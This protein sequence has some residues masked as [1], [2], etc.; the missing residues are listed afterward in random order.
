MHVKLSALPGPLK[1]SIKMS[2]KLPGAN[3][4]KQKLDQKLKERRPWEKQIAT[5]KSKTLSFK[6]N[7]ERLTLSWCRARHVHLK[8]AD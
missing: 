6:I 2:C 4:L 1:G 8:T 3:S 5:Q 7:A